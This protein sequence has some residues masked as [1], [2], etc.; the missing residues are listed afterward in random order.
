MNVLKCQ[1]CELHE[2]VQGCPYV[3]V[4]LLR[5]RNVMCVCY[6]LMIN[7]HQT[8]SYLDAKY[9]AAYTLSPHVDN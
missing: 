8:R 4:F 5:T 2:L 1:H 7:I 3:S 6:T 9:T